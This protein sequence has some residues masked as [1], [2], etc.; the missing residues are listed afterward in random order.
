MAEEARRVAVETMGVLR[1]AGVFG[2]EMFVDGGRVLINEIAPRVHNLGHHTLQSSATS[3]FEQHLRAILGMELGS[4]EL[5]RDAVMYNILGPPGFE[6]RYLPPEISG[7]GMHLKMYGKAESRPARKLG[8][9]NVVGGG[10]DEL[11]RRLDSVRGAAAVRP[12]G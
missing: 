6:G 7:E 9:L 11:L 8:H 3:Q 10:R 2:I 4:A 5:L 1:G 12:A